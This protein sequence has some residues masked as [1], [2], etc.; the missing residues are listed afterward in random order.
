MR[1]FEE[2]GFE[3]RSE[4]DVSSELKRVEEWVGDEAILLGRF[5]LLVIDWTLVGAFLTKKARS[6]PQSVFERTERKTRERGLTWS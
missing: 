1:R 3:G 4:V 6:A 5:D 2:K